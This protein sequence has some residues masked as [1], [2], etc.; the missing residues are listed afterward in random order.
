MDMGTNII[1][2]SLMY[3]QFGLQVIPLANSCCL[4]VGWWCYTIPDV[5]VLMWTKPET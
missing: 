1:E 2:A 5:L 3:P 4:G